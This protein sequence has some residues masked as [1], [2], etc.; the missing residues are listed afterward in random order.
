MAFFR[1]MA[2]IPAHACQLAVL[3]SSDEKAAEQCVLQQSK[4]WSIAAGRRRRSPAAG[5]GAA[6]AESGTPAADHVA[7]SRGD[8]KPQPAS[9]ASALGEEMVVRSKVATNNSTRRVLGR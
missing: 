1:K 9:G 7:P 8:E 3:I 5:G 4:S 6:V 2:S